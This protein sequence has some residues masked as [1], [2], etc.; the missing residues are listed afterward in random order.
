TNKESLGNPANLATS[1]APEFKLTP[2][3]KR[4]SNI[5][6]SSKTLN[7]V[8]LKQTDDNCSSSMSS[9]ISTPK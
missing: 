2:S 3:F 6:L 5:T 9:L 7:P 4:C 1:K 8:F